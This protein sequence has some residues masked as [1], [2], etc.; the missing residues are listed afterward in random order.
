MLRHTDC[1]A[2]LVLC[3][4]TNPWSAALLD[5]LG[6]QLALVDHVSIHRYRLK[7]GPQTTFSADEYYRLLEEAD[8]TKAF[9]LSTAEFIEAATGGTRRIGIALGEWAVWYPEAREFCAGANPR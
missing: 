1:S 8:E 3:G 2:E 7:G 4:D 5:T 9:L 6:P